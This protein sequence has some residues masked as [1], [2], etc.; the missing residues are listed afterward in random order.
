VIGFAALRSIA[1]LLAG[2]Q[3]ALTQPIR[4]DDVVIVENEWGRV[5]D[6]TLTETIRMARRKLALANAAVADS[7]TPS[8]RLEIRTK[9]PAGSL[10]Q[11]TESARSI[12]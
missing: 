5:E 10:R 1:T 2:F 8:L 11:P 3:I 9:G 7:R 4:V 12:A 6:V